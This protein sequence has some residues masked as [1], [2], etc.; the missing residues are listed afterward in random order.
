M[1]LPKRGFPKLEC[2]YCANLIQ[3]LSYAGSRKS[4]E[5]SKKGSVVIISGACL[6][7]PSLHMCEHHQL[8]I[9]GSQTCY[10]VKGGRRQLDNL[11]CAFW[12]L[13]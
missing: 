11:L 2:A 9:S 7:F 4:P 10:S 8:P 3:T 6:F 12:V 1:K 13:L 5:Y